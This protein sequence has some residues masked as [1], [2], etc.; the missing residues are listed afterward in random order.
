MKKQVRSAVEALDT[1]VRRRNVF[2]YMA[3]SGNLL[4]ED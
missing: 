2:D 1:Q 3:I 4:H